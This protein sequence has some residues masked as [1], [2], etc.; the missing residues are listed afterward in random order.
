[1]SKPPKVLERLSRN[2]LDALTTHVLNKGNAYLEH[3]RLMQEERDLAE[4]KTAFHTISRHGFHTGW[5]AQLIRLMTSQTPDQPWDP[6]GTGAVQRSW[7]QSSGTEARM[8]ERNP[9]AGARTAQGNQTGAFFSPEV[10]AMAISQAE[11]ASE[12]LRDYA[13]AAVRTATGVVEEAFNYIEVVVPCAPYA[14]LSFSKGPGF[15]QMA[16]DN[17]VRKINA[18]LFQNTKLK[19]REPEVA[20]LISMDQLLDDLK[21]KAELLTHAKVVF[22]CIDGV[23]DSKNAD[24][25]MLRKRLDGQSKWAL[26]TAYPWHE[27]PRLNPT[28]KTGKWTGSM[29]SRFK[30]KVLIAHKWVHP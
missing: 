18:F 26:H 24:E 28:V 29:I 11:T 17:V 10:E 3:N 23:I 4:K 6:Y 7:T 8:P 13:Y 25:Q 1:M 14:G 22:K 20:K 15:V 16:H 30:S 2:E 21:V 27:T 5:E 12:M 9:R 19:R